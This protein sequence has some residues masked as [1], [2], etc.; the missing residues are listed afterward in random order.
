MNDLVI[1]IM[2]YK[3]NYVCASRF[4]LQKQNL[5]GYKNGYK[6]KKRARV[7]KTYRESESYKN[8]ELQNGLQRRLQKFIQHTPYIV[9]SGIC[10]G[11]QKH[12]GEQRARVIQEGDPYSHDTR[13]SYGNG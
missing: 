7:T 2:G 10:S 4:G 3:N 8:T 12:H 9:R 5:L 1:L 13:H 6:N 11:L